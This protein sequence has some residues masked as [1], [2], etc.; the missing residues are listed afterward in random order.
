MVEKGGSVLVT[1]DGAALTRESQLGGDFRLGADL[2]RVAAL[3][4]EKETGD[5]TSTTVLLTSALMRGIEKL[6]VASDWDPVR[7]TE[8]LRA[9]TLDVE[10]YLRSLSRPASPSTLHRVAEMAAHGE[11]EIAEKVVQ[12]VLQVGEEGSVSISPHEGTGLVLEH[13]EGLSLEQGWASF[14]MCPPGAS[15]RDMDGPLVAVFRQVLRRTEDVSGAMEQASQ[16][17]GRG[18]VIFSPGIQGDALSTVLLNDQKKVISCVAVE[19]RG[20]PRDLSDWIDDIATVTNATV[21]DPQTGRTPKNFESSWLGYARRILLTR[22][23][24]TLISYMDEDIIQAIDLRASALKARAEASSHPY[25]RDRLSERAAAL[26]G[27]LV[28]LKVGGRTKQEAQDRRS[29]TEDALLAVQSA[30]KGGV[31]PGAGISYLKAR[32]QVPNTEGGKILSHA[33]SEPFLILAERA[34]KEPLVELLKAGERTLDPEIVDPV[35]VGC[36]ALRNAVSVAV[37]IA[38]CGGVVKGKT[39]GGAIPRRSVR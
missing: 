34:G 15:E 16:W 1:T 7:V 22:D 12:A 10:A 4:T 14:G 29:R 33:L 8:E 9:A 32:F 11:T 26:D 17:P 21:V 36:S 3:Q 23:R 2:V 18:L 27:G 19:Y 37:Q 35:E 20:S 39:V 13:R 28:T 31:I 25:D 30:L 5:G 6:S 38:L 24:T